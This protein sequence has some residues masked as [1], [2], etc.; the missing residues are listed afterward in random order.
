MIRLFLVIAV[1]AMTAACVL[2]NGGGLI[3]KGGGAGGPIHCAGAR[4]P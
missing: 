3:G 2:R 4:C 1:A